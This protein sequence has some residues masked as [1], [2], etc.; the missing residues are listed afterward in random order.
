MT[1]LI[2]SID[3]EED[4]WFRSRDVSVG[5][6]RELP[7][8]ARFFAHLGVRP[9]YLVNYQV[10][11]D[12]SAAAVLRDVTGAGSNAEIGAHLHPW[13]TP[14]LDEAFVPRNSMLKNLPADLQRAKL[15]RVT[16]TLEQAFAA[17]PRVFRAGRF[18]IGRDTVPAL[19]SCGYSVDSS[20]TPFWSWES[21][22]DG[23]NFVGAPIDAYRLEPGRDV[24]HPSLYGDLIEI[25]LSYGFSRGPFGFWD[26]ARRVVENARAPLKWLRLAGLVDRTGLAKRIVLC[27]ELASAAE[28]V[29]LSQRLLEHGAR[30][31]QVF[32]HSPSLMPGLSPFVSSWADVTRLYDTIAAYLDGVSRL[33][34]VRFATLSEAASLL[35]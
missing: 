32:F 15:E 35:T 9:T 27:P 13:N 16:T 1:V 29:T 19:L 7:R 21:Y 31:L 8:L 25:P 10:A 12:P 33:T 4:N 17:R 14:P 2:I 20:V 34:N 30:H 18:G 5:N 11:I 6:I 23:P 22:D 26:S 24:R 28:M 3:T